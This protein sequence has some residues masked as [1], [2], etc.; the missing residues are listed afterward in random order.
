[1]IHSSLSLFVKKEE[2]GT[3][4][5]KIYISFFISDLTMISKQQPD[6][7]ELFNADET[8]KEK[9]MRISLVKYLVARQQLSLC[10]I[11]CCRLTMMIMV[12]MRSLC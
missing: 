12:K 9:N 11:L 3:E 6:D 5:R 4:K 8:G 1:M 7:Y 2:F 10:S